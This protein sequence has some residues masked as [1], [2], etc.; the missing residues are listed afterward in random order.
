MSELEHD[1]YDGEE[2]ADDPSEALQLPLTADTPLPDAFALFVES[3][4]L[5]SLTGARQSKTVWCVQWRDHPDALHRLVAMWLQ[6]QEVEQSPAM[7]HDFLR[8][9]VD[10]HL[11][12]LV[13]ADQGVLRACGNGHRV[14]VRLDEAGIKN[15]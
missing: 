6:W 4:L 13:G 7:L 14:H 12:Y 8:N 10:Y 2:F 11:P 1:H 15:Q 5:G 9:V 3:T